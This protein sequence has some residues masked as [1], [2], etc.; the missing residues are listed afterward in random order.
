M[1]FL[2]LLP[3]PFFGPTKRN[4]KGRVSIW[5]L[6]TKEIFHNLLVDKER[7]R[8]SKNRH[9]LKM[10]EMSTKSESYGPPGSLRDSALGPGGQ[11]REAGLKNAVFTKETPCRGEFSSG[12]CHG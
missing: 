6:E 12:R 4:A 3:H 5:T 2:I 11:E 1:V 7:P 8:I 9:K 10:V